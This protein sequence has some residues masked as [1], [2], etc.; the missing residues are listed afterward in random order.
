[1]LKPPAQRGDII[2]SRLSVPHTNRLARHR[3]GA[4]E[5]LVLVHG[6]GESVVG[7]RPVHDELS[8]DYDVIAIDLPGFGGSPSL[9][10]GGGADGGGFGGCG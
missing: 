10:P 8:K 3:T 9:P 5:P 6:V 7:W 4:G 1:M 2:A